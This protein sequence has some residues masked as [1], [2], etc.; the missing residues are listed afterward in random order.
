MDAATSRFG[1]TDSALITPGHC[2]L[3]RGTQGPFVDTHVEDDF[4][5]NAYLCV[6]CVTEM[7]LLLGITVDANALAIKKAYNKGVG[8]TIKKTRGRL[9]GLFSDLSASLSS[10]LISDL[11]ST[12]ATSPEG[13]PEHDGDEEGD[14]IISA[15]DSTEDGIGSDGTSV[16]SSGS[17]GSEG[18]DDLSGDPI[19]G[20]DIFGTAGRS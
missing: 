18:R 12:G 13:V 5:G 8:D 15:G 14:G 19:D 9:N 1:V 17:S 6:Q 3:C 20:T 11:G 10:A 7:S 16:E 2:L 4:R